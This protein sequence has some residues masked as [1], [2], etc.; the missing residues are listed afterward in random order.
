M[1]TFTCILG[2]SG[3]LAM[4]WKIF[5][6]FAPWVPFLW[7]PR[8][9]FY[10]DIPEIPRPI[11]EYPK[12]QVYPEYRLQADISGYPLPKDFEIWV[13]SGWV[14][15]KMFCSGSGWG[16]RRT[17]L[18][19]R[20]NKQLPSVMRTKERIQSI[21]CCFHLGRAP[22]WLHQHKLSYVQFLCL[23]T[24]FLPWDWFLRRL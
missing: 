14:S 17:L 10:S 12:L 22:E 1:N 9:D 6:I 20:E 19:V 24:P 11:W 23:S 5:H 18:L 15:K 3:S 16:T 2:M 8:L 21:W 13:G 4:N 7:V